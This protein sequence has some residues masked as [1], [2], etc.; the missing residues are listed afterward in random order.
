MTP[1]LRTG[2]VNGLAQQP[3]HE[4]SML[5][6]ALPAVSLITPCYPQPQRLLRFENQNVQ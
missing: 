5:S 2:V 4:M 3:R 6:V 1:P